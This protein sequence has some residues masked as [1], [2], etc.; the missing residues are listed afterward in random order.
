MDKIILEKKNHS[1]MHVGCDFGIANELSD[2]FSFFVPG[3]KYMPAF[4]N[5]VWD[6]KIRLFNVQSNEI[7]V[8]L[9]P[10]IKDFCAKRNYEIEL[11]D[12]NN[13][14]SPD[15]KEVIDPKEIMNFVSS[16]EIKS[17]GKPIEIR[18]YQFNAVCHALHNK[19]S[20]LVS[21][22]GSGKSLIIYILIK[23]YLSM[24]NSNIQKVLIIVPT[25]SLVDQMYADFADY[26][27][28]VEEGCHKI[29]SG[30][31][32]MTNA[33][34]VISTWQSIYKLPGK[35]FEQFGCIIG[36]ECHGFKSKSLNS[37]MNKAREA[38]Y[39]FGTTGTLDGTQTHELVLQGLYG[40]IYNV[41]TTKKLQDND[42][43]AK[44]FINV[45]VLK[46]TEEIRKSRGKQIYQ[47]E[48]DYIV[49]NE[50]RNKFI[51][52]LATTQTGNTLV[53]FQFVEKHGKILF[54]MIRDDVDEERKVFYVSGET[55]TGDREAIRGIV[56]TQPNSIIVAS[57]G[58]FSTGINIRNLHNIIFASP[59]KSQIRVLQ[60]IGRSLRKS[61]DG[62][63]AKLYDI[64][65]DLH[66][67]GRKNF[68]LEHSAERIKIYNK[69]KFNYKVYEVELK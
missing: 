9:Y 52:N 43:L 35:W 64:A 3:Y 58:T 2:F 49:R 57:M 60:S 36:D 27:M 6:G 38:E 48:I 41:T 61:D 8:G 54:D 40:R 10:F 26:G 56:E 69:Q 1:I 31:E 19:R 4:R 28:N 50:S 17:R 67:L 66:W 32:K 21:P 23:Y 34:T 16:L 29:Y 47:D 11:S 42:T 24:L 5:K 37:I 55:A 33:G 30:K 46:Y 59:S 45:I 51:R 65:D 44:L 12:E 14:G 63:E 13:Y 22:T 20:V 39:R 18:D 62:R 53:L 25:T 7:H 68:A 15:D